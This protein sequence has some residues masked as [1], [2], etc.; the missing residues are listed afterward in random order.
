MTTTS[1]L[2]WKIPGRVGDSPI[3]G[4]GQYCDNEVGAV[5][6]QLRQLV[7]GQ[8]WR[9]AL[10]LDEFAEGLARHIDAG[11][12]LEAGCLPRR[13]RAI[14]DGDIGI[15]C[16]NKN[17][18]RACGAAVI[19]VAKDDARAVAWDQARD[20]QLEP[21]QRNRARMQQMTFRED[22]LFPD[23]DDGELGAVLE[24]LP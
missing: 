13:A 17:R 24:P 19:V 7:R 22:E 18:G 12:K 5:L 15:T 14:E 8:A 3:I 23:I 16:A 21:A 1:G 2:S 10:V 20:Q 11:K 6:H 4:A 9:G